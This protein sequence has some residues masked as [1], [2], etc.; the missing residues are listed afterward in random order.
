MVNEFIVGA[1]AQK[2]LNL[3]AKE[4]DIAIIVTVTGRRMLTSIIKKH[5]EGVEYRVSA[6][7]AAI[8][9]V[10]EDMCAEFFGSTTYNSDIL[11]QI[12][13]GH[14]GKIMI[15][16]LNVS[17]ILLLVINQLDIKKDKLLDYI[18]SLKNLMPSTW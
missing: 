3:L 9:N 4:V 14:L 8:L 18:Y 15:A 16:S 11:I 7:T 5:D 10:I 2:I 17:T 6:M 13:K 1:E 12:S